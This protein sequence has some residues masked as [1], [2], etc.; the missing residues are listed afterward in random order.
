MVLYLLSKNR[1][2]LCGR[3]KMTNGLLA[4][5]ETRRSDE[6]EERARLG[7]RGLENRECRSRN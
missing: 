5:K 2:S 3:C 1:R 7:D 6:P 4:I